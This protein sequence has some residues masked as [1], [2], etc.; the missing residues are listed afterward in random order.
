M[1][2]LV[3]DLQQEVLK[4]DCDILNS[5]RKAHLIAAKLKLA[6]FDLGIMSELNGN[7][8]KHLRP[9]QYRTVKGSLKARNPYNGWIPVQL[10]NSKTEQFFVQTHSLCQYLKLLILVIGHQGLSRCYFP[11]KV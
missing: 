1:S 4:P 8:G 5:L 7:Y 11:E 3:L 10:P 2:S 9:P 6:E